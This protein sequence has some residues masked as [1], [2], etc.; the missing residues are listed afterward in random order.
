[1][2]SKPGKIIRYIPELLLIL[3]C[4][5]HPHWGQHPL[6]E[7]IVFEKKIFFEREREREITKTNLTLAVGNEK[8]KEEEK[9]EEH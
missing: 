8:L 9:P 2:V 7:F 3:N 4:T 1:M 6:N 5:S